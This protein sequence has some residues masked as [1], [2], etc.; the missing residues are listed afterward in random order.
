MLLIVNSA[1]N[2]GLLGGNGVFAHRLV[3][4]LF[5]KSTNTRWQIYV[6]H[7]IYI[8][9]VNFLFSL[10]SAKLWGQVYFVRVMLIG[11]SLGFYEPSSWPVGIKQALIMT[12]TWH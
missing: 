5:M 2:I 1:Y 6:K 4:I 9:S 12:L 7:K 10:S 3:T 8:T 11:F